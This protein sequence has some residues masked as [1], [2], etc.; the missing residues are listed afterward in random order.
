[1]LVFLI[2]VLLIHVF[3]FCMSE[4]KRSLT[5]V[6]TKATK[7]PETTV[8]TSVDESAAALEDV[9]KKVQDAVESIIPTQ[10]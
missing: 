7:E 6:A 8:N 1:M 10:F 5:V 2:L 3:T 9:L 4:P